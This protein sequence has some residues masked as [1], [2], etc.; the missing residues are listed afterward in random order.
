MLCFQIHILQLAVC[1]LI[2]NLTW[3]VVPQIF[4]ELGQLNSVLVMPF[5]FLA[6]LKGET[7][8]AFSRVL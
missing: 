8:L 3:L 2:L 1:Y 6:P 7:P 5:I 4:S